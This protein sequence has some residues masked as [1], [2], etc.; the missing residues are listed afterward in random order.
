[1]QSNTRGDLATIR[2]LMWPGYIGYV[3]KEKNTFGGVYYGNG[4]KNSDLAFYL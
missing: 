1:M 2:S 3:F 4:I